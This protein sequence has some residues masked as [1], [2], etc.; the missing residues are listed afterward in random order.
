MVAI[1]SGD[2]KGGKDAG[3][4]GGKVTKIT[5][6]EQQALD[7]FTAFPMPIAQAIQRIKE[8]S[9]KNKKY[10]IST[11]MPRRFNRDAEPKIYRDRSPSADEAKRMRELRRGN[12]E[13][14][15]KVFSDKE[16]MGISKEDLAIAEI[17]LRQINQNNEGIERK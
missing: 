1:K 12:V 15:I 10:D 5:N 3:D 8:D 2:G 4:G 13:N 16:N 11:L 6:R 17:I 7:K 14:D 9:Q